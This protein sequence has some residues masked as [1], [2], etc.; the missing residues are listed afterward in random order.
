MTS[1]VVWRRCPYDVLITPER[2]REDL[3]VIYLAH[4]VD[5]SGNGY[6]KTRMKTVG[7]MLDN[8]ITIEVFSRLLYLTGNYKD[9]NGIHYVFKQ[10][11]GTSTAKSPKGMFETLSIPNDLQLVLNK[12][13]QYEEG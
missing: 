12:I 6:V 13:K 1:I 4:S 3:T 10:N 7:K 11:D 2:L 8:A 5:E 9:E